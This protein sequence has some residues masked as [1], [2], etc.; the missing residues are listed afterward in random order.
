MKIERKQIPFYVAFSLPSPIAIRGSLSNDHGYGNVD[1]KK[2]I[3]LGWQ[4]NNFARASCI[5]VHFIA[6]TSRLRS[7]TSYNNFQVLWWTLT[8]G[9]DFLFLFVN[10]DT[11]L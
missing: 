1:D 8:K 5:F 9:N 7:E 6:V 2:A 10:L 3:C 11:V 4:N